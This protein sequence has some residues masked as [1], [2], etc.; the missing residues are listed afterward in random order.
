MK[1]EADAA[2]GLYP[3]Q[4]GIKPLGKELMRFLQIGSNSDLIRLPAIADRKLAWGR[5]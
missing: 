4:D 5:R 3:L 2:S 1:R